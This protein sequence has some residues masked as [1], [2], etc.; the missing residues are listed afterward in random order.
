MRSISSATKGTATSKLSFAPASSSVNNTELV[1]DDVSTAV[2]DDVIGRGENEVAEA[3]GGDWDADD[4]VI[5]GGVACVDDVIDGG[6]ASVDDVIGVIDASDVVITATA[7][8]LPESNKSEKDDID[9]IAELDEGN[10]TEATEGEEEDV[11]SL[12]RRTLASD[13]VSTR[14]IMCCCSA[15][16]WFHFL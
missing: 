14:S 7:D 5:S 4:D 8:G 3:M 9:A 13:K 16:S 6:V 15:E 1:A 11:R 12:V 10:A 2:A